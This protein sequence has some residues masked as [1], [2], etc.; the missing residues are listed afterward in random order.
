MT[1]PFASA[2]SAQSLP[3]GQGVE[4]TEVLVDTVGEESWI[5]FRFLAPEIARDGGQIDYDAAAPDMDVLCN[6][7]ALPYL[8]DF[9]LEAGRIA[10]SLSDRPVP[11]GMADPEAT[12]FIE[13]YRIDGN[14][15]IWEAF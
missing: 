13:V 1:I 9:E 4:L 7:T 11:F 6:E 15:C 3:S 10:I 12:Q 5:R 2:A 14:R 8:N